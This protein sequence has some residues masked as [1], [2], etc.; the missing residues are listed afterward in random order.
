MGEYADDCIEAGM[1]SCHPFGIR[2]NRKTTYRPLDFKEILKE[3]DKARLVKMS[4]AAE[5]WFPKSQSFIVDKTIHVANWLLDRI[6]GQ[7]DIES[8]GWIEECDC[9]EEYD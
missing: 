1:M 5:F 4:G 3:T 9:D 6:A 8:E 7:Q 2:V